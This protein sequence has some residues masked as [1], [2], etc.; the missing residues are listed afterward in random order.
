MEDDSLYKI[1]SFINSNNEII[2]PKALLSPGTRFRKLLEDGFIKV[3]E[4]EERCYL[5]LTEKGK[6]FI[7]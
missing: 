2:V 4:S 7:F 6:A 1:L 3:N 5:T